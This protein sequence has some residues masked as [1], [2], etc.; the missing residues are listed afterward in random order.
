[1]KQQQPVQALNSEVT[2]YGISQFRRRVVPYREDLK[3]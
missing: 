3:K 1:M 2:S